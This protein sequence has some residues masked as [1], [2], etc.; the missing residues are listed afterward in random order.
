MFANSNEYRVLSHASAPQVEELATAA[1]SYI[2]RGWSVIP[3]LGKRPAIA[4]WKVYQSRFPTAGEVAD[5]WTPREKPATGIGIITGSLSHLVVV[6][7][8]TIASA[9][10][11]SDRFPGSPLT[12]RTGRGGVHIYYLAPSDHEIGNRA[13][14]FHQPIDLRGNGGYVAAPPSWHPSGK[15]YQWAARDLE[16]PLPRFDP[17]WLRESQSQ[18]ND[19]QVTLPATATIRNAFA[20]IRCIHATS[21]EGGH[22]ATFRAACKLRA[23]GLTR[24][25]ALLLLTEWNKTNA[26]PPW[27]TSELQHKIDSAYQV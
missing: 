8:D 11:W 24:D 25:D 12:V 26:H 20:Y 4:T 18:V 5:W 19:S 17:T 27:S 23:T 7:C 9:Q 6:D 22:N 14:I 21:G 1:S 15:N 2:E 13:K 3:L 16:G 10:Y